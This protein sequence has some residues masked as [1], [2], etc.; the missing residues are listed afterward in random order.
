MYT[1][2]VSLFEEIM[3]RLD[4][5][6]RAKEKFEELDTNKSGFLESEELVIVADWVL[7]TYGTVDDL[8]KTKT[9]IMNRIDENKDGLLSLQEFTVLI[10]EVNARVL[11]MKHAMNKFH[12]LDNN[13]NGV[14]DHDE[15]EE[16]TDYVLKTFY[17]DGA[18]LSK[19]DKQSFKEKMMKE[20]D[21]NNDGRLTLDEFSILFDK[22]YTM[23]RE[24]FSKK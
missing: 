8:E 14:L 9:M 7:K 5:N 18:P 13:G 20:V 23:N 19:E 24:K 11:A 4:I 22:Q 12:E 6:R 17:P 2:F 3:E 1:E 21:M 10:E 16:V 15:L